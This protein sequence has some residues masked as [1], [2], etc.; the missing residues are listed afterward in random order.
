M[1][2]PP[3]IETRRR[4]RRRRALLGVVVVAVVAGATFGALSGGGGGSS[5]SRHAAAKTPATAVARATAGVLSSDVHVDVAPAPLRVAWTR[6]GDVPIYGEPNPS[7]KP[8]RSLS[9]RTTYQQVRTLLA[10]DQ[11][12]DWLH[13]YLPTKPNNTTA[14]VKANDVNV[15]VPLDYAIK[16][17]L[18][19]HKVTLLHNGAVEFESAVVIGA[20]DTPTPT[21]IFYITDPVDL[22]SNPNAGYGVFAIGL[23]GHSNVL[24]EFGGGDGQIALHG[25]NTPGDVGRDL[26]HGC[27]R[28]PND[29]IM[30]L[31]TLP[32]G[33]PVVIT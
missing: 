9:S 3:R 33:T 7:A 12:G 16:V 10:F 30:R 26:S 11:V 21:G 27:V 14:W 32:L 6:G 15:S 2:D 29:A 17:S 22:H 8:L 20:K 31:S 18:A 13:V 23:S 4:Q 5:P 25:T 1:S 19:D 28:M 24:D